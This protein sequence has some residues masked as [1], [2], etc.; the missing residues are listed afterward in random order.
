MVRVSSLPCLAFTGRPDCKPLQ[1]GSVSCCVSS[2]GTCC[3]F[4]LHL[5]DVALREL[6]VLLL[7]C[8]SFEYEHSMQA[9]TSVSITFMESLKGT[10]RKLTMHLGDGPETQEVEVDVPAGIENGSQ[11]LM[12]DIIRTQQ[13]R[14]SLVV[15]VQLRVCACLCQLARALENTVFVPPMVHESLHVHSQNL[16]CVS[17]SI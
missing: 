12:Q 15:Q 3:R 1:T 4:Y 5:F 14:V 11:L 9:S 10:K 6:F 2:L 16:P 17:L 8:T 13:N 7:A